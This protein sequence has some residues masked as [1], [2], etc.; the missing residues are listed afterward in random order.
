MRILLITQ[1][2]DPENAIKG[3]SFVKALAQKGYEVEVLTTFPSYPGGKLYAGFRQKIYQI[4]Y[5][6]G[7]KVVR[8]ASYISHDSSILKRLLNYSSFGISC[9]LY[10]M[11]F[12]NRPRIIYAYHPAIVAGLAAW[13]IGAVKR[14]PFIYDVQ[15]LWPDALTDSGTLKVGKI[16]R[17]IGRVADFIY[18]KSAHVIVLSDGYRKILMDRGVSEDKITRI[19]NWCDESRVLPNP[20]ATSANIFDDKRFNILYAGNF[21]AAQGLIY[22]LDAAKITQQTS[23]HIQ[24]ILM[25]DGIEVQVLKSKV[26]DEKLENVCFIPRIPIDKIGEVAKHADALLIHLK[27]SPAYEVT[28]PSKTQSSLALGKPI[29]MATGGEAAAL[30]RQA[31]AG[32]FSKPCNAA[33][34][35]SAAIELANK[36]EAELS[37]MGANASRFYKENLSMANGVTA[38]DAVLNRIGLS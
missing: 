18:R 32:V 1:L 15:D 4:E 2:F 8:L 28:I 21:G 35:A 27:A 36:S 5:Y 11:F 14:V 23:S 16:S 33:T 22:V 9:L 19:Y 30:V 10:G 38:L 13:V 7:V 24:F 25:G 37:V 20:E 34:I 17:S 31:C 6:H 12:S 3:L 29:L 26:I